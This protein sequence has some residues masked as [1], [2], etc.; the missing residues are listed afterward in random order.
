MS[1]FDISRH[2]GRIEESPHRVGEVAALRQIELLIPE[3]LT[4]ADYN[5]GDSRSIHY[6]ARTAD[7]LAGYAQYDPVTARLRQM[8]VVSKQRGGQLGR[9]LVECVRDEARR[10][11][12]RELRVHAWTR[13]IDFYRRVG[14]EAVGEVHSDARVPWQAMT[15]RLDG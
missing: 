9:T 3:G 15:L 10:R 4:M 14:F 13:S 6:V 7:R 2:E 8:V 12:E 11:G 1:E 5:E